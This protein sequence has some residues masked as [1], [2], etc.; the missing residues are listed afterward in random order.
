MRDPSRHPWYYRYRRNRYKPWAP[1]AGCGCLMLI[2]LLL[3]MFIG[4]LPA[5]F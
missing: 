1:Y 3:V 2:L 5:P 4:L